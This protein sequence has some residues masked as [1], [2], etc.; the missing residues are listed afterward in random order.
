MRLNNYIRVIYMGDNKVGKTMDMKSYMN[1]YMKEY[2][3]MNRDKVNERIKCEIC[4]QEYS[5]SNKSRH[6]KS[7]QHMIMVLNKRIDEL[8]KININKIKT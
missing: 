4:D 1:Q 7:K 8:E 2:R 3:E 6:V 5:K